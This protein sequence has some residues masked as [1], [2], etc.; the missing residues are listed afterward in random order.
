M[1]MK[2]ITGIAGH[3]IISS[4]TNRCRKKLV[5][6]GISAHSHVREADHKSCNFPQYKRHIENTIAQ[7]VPIAN[8]RAV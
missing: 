1:K 6:T 8:A 5:I 4:A 2:E 7:P 3:E